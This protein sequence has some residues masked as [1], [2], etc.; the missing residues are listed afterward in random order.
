MEVRRVTMPSTVTEL[1]WKAF[2]YCFN[3]VEVELNEG[4]WMIGDSAFECYSASRSV[5]IPSTVTN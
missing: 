5:T 3:L 2:H 1:G 4:L